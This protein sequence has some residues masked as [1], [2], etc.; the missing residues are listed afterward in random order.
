M[1][2]LHQQSRTVNRAVPIRRR[3]RLVSTSLSPHQLDSP[4]QAACEV[5]QVRQ[6]HFKVSGVV[7]S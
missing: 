2:L 3:P 7:E 1:L 5:E 4:T 6:Q